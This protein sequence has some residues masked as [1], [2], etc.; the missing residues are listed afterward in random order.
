MRRLELG[1]R[2]PQLAAAL[3]VTFQQV[4]KYEDGSNRMSAGRLAVAAAFLDVPITY[5][6]GENLSPE[7]TEE[8]SLLRPVGAMDLLCLYNRIRSAQDRQ[9]LLQLA[10]ALARRRQEAA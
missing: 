6:F 4:Q 7:G 3:G 9:T 2:Q 5:F 10:R 1:I 8:V